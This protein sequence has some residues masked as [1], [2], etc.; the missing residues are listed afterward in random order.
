MRHLLGS[1]EAAGGLAVA[2]TVDS[3]TRG[4]RE[5][6]RWFSRRSTRQGPPR[7]GNFEGYPGPPRIGD[8]ALTWAIVDWLRANTR[9]PV[10]LKGMLLVKTPELQGATGWTDSSSPITVAGRRRAAVAPSNACLKSWPRWLA[11]CRC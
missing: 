6:E 8:P 1:A 7:M 5:G 10:F 3:P 2:L 11:G 4:N 9:L